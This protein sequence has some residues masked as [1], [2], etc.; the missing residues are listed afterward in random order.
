[1]LYKIGIYNL[2]T[3]KRLGVDYFRIL[4]MLVLVYV[5]M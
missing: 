2:S 3:S 5:C 4:N 1:M